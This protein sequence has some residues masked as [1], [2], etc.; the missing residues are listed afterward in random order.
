MQ[1]VWE[2]NYLVGSRYIGNK[3]MIYLVTSVGQLI[4]FWWALTNKVVDYCER[5]ID[6]IRE[7]MGKGKNKPKPKNG[8]RRKLT[9]QASKSWVVKQVKITL[10]YD[11]VN[12][13]LAA[14]R[15]PK[16]EQLV[17]TIINFLT[18]SGFCLEGPRTKRKR[19]N[20]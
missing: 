14:T 5:H 20:S 19:R 10:N 15:Q 11:H 1:I 9:E 8:K 4:F 3:K 6:D 7:H 13:M 18:F 16:T 17:K 2:S 12:S